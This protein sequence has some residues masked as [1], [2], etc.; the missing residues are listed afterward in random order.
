MQNLCQK[1]I[2]RN[3]KIGSL[4]LHVPSD[5]AGLKYRSQVTGHRSKQ[6]LWIFGEFVFGSY[7]F[8]FFSLYSLFIPTNPMMSSYFS[9]VPSMRFQ[10]LWSPHLS[11]FFSPTCS[12]NDALLMVLLP[13]DQIMYARLLWKK[14]CV[15][16]CAKTSIESYG[17]SDS[18]VTIFFYN[19]AIC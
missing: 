6:Y 15:L 18:K 10:S 4:W 2:I 11:R 9:T 3:L 19:I 5:T 17:N 14:D 7:L 8:T 1:T 12:S 16:Y 13:R